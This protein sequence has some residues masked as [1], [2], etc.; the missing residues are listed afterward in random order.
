MEWKKN[1]CGF[2]YSRNMANFEAFHQNIS[3]SINFFFLK[4]RTIYIEKIPITCIL[5]QFYIQNDYFSGKK[6]CCPSEFEGDKYSISFQTLNS[7]WA[8]N[9]ADSNSKQFKDGLKFYQKELKTFLVGPA[10]SHQLLSFELIKFK[11]GPKN[12]IAIETEIRLKQSH[13]NNFELIQDAL[14]SKAKE[15]FINGDHLKGE[16]KTL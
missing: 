10:F 5:L 7:T 6:C 15:Y 2:S 11:R 1:S 16:S 3:S 14:I 13:A 4:S 12:V 8:R 9:L